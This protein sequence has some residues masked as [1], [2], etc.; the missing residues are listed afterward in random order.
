MNTLVQYSV[1]IAMEV[2]IVMFLILLLA[3]CCWQKKIFR[4]TKSFRYLLIFM[5]FILINQIITWNLLIYNVPVRYGLMPMRIVYYLDYILYYGASLAI[6]HYVESL[7]I[8]GMERLEVAYTPNKKLHTVMIIW[9]VVTSLIYEVSLFVPSIYHVEE[10]ISIYSIYSIY[11]Y[12]GMHIMVKFVVVWTIILILRYRKVIGKHD[13]TLCLVFTILVSGFIIVDEL[14]G[15]CI[16][17][18]LMSLFTF[19]LYVRIDLH[20]ELM[21][22]RQEK[23]VALW[24]TQIMLSQMQPH[25]LYNVFTTISSMCEMQ[26]ATEARDVVNHFA[27]YFRANLESLGTERTISFEKELEHV[28]T[29]LWLEKVRFEDILNICYDIETTDFSIPPLTIQPIVENAVKHGIHPKENGGTVTVRS[30]ETN[31]NY[32]VVVED[33]GVG[34]DVNKK[35]DDNRTHVGIENVSKRLEAICNGTCDIQSGLGKGTV[36]TITIPKEM[37]R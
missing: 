8:E 19:I 13:S 6:Y 35:N 21:I 3:T 32:V 16:S 10:G 26:N 7:V 22:E 27:D 36:V 12:V 9:G 28:K 4:T 37:Y 20:R 11:A 29:Y 15:V 33:D 34:F 30:Y 31:E 2:T 1:N 18:V 14:C 24:K 5:I 23:E 17:Y 25:F